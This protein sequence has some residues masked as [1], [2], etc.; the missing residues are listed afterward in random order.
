[1]TVAPYRAGSQERPESKALVVA[2]S[3][4]QLGFV[5]L[6]WLL[7]IVPTALLALGAFLFQGLRRAARPPFDA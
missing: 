7:A 3:V 2:I 5:V 6:V 1:M 4:L